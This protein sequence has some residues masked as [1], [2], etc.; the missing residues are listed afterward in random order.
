MFFLG[1]IYAMAKSWIVYPSWGIIINP[2]WKVFFM[3]FFLV[4]IYIYTYIYLH[5][6]IHIFIYIYIVYIYI[7]TPGVCI[8][9]LLLL[10]L[11][12]F[13]S[14]RTYPI[15]LFY[16]SGF[17]CHGM[18]DRGPHAFQVSWRW[19]TY[20]VGD[21]LSHVFPIY[22]WLPQNTILLISHIPITAHD[23]FMK[24]IIVNPKKIIKT[25]K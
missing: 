15:M 25:K 2:F 21:N 11:F 10:L 4:N 13:E 5:I 18:D 1:T 12:M 22:R 8:Y 7:Y 3:I 19:Y 23:S 17:R 20:H 14:M 16:V 24:V 9:I 6:Y